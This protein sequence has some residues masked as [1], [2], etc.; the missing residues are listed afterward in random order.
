M[1][2]ANQYISQMD[3]VVRDAVFG[4][5]GTIISF[6]VSPTDAPFLI[7]QFEPQFSEEDLVN[8]NNRNFVISTIIKGQKVQA[9][10][11]QSLNLSKSQTDFTD[12]IVENNRALYSKTRS[13]AEEEVKNALT[14]PAKFQTK[15]YL[16]A[17]QRLKETY[18]TSGSP[19]TAPRP[20]EQS[21]S[22]SVTPVSPPTV[23]AQDL[24]PTNDNLGMRISH[25]P[26]K[27]QKLKQNVTQLGDSIF[28]ETNAKGESVLHLRGNINDFI[29]RTPVTPPQQP[30]MQNNQPKPNLPGQNP[31]SRRNKIRFNKQK[32]N[33]NNK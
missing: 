23:S 12:Q 30:Q 13:E 20:V 21:T 18:G 1:T 17:Q 22:P 15:A 29:D 33:F 3:E 24:R 4:N 6:R 7:Q 16:E 2:V 14:L 8:L 32:P 27:P 10:S 9:F 25:E 11:A 26:P 28:A 5:V 19:I 31:Q